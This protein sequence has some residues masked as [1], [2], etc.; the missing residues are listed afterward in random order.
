MVWVPRE[1]GSSV[2][3]QLMLAELV[4]NFSG[5]ECWG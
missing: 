4:G 3:Y 5:E 2:W 1:L